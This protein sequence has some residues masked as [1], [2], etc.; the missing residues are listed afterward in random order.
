MDKKLLSGK[1]VKKKKIGDY[2]L[3]L[4]CLSI[5]VNMSLTFMCIPQETGLL[6]IFLI[7][8][9]K[10]KMKQSNIF[11]HINKQKICDFFSC[12]SILEFIFN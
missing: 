1:K 12:F 2:F 10:K 9:P 7:V 3:H 4:N 5:K 6:Y 11:Y 8:Y